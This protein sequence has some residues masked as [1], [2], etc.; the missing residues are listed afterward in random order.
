MPSRCAATLLCMTL[1]GCS[2]ATSGALATQA[3]DAHS[4]FTIV[5]VDNRHWSAVTV[6]AVRDGMRRRLGTVVTAQTGR[7][8]VPSYLI[9]PLRRIQLQA[10]PDGIG[11]GITTGLM[12]V[13]PGQRVSWTLEARLEMS[14][15][16]VW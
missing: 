14:S 13:G 6:Y 10:V 1:L 11:V 12:P 2:S 5:E 9:D 4:R 7:F 16:G 3:S 15:V 8:H